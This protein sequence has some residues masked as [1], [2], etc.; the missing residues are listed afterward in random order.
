M[1]LHTIKNTILQTYTD[2]KVRSFPFSCSSILEQYQFKVN[3]YSYL[4]SKNREL[5][6]I[7][8]KFTH[9]AFTFGPVICYNDAMP[10]ERIRFSLMHELGHFLLHTESETAANQFASHILAPRCIISKLNMKDAKEVAQFFFISKEAA[11][12]A[13]KD[14]INADSRMEQDQSDVFLLRHFYEP[15]KQIYIFRISECPVCGADI[16]N[17]TKNTC[18]QCKKLSIKSR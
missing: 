8:Q 6:E 9:D 3:S 12:Y 2:L 14:A 1:N 18:I 17:S 11:S 13:L 15:A 5:Y 4:R 10:E 7:C 16:Y